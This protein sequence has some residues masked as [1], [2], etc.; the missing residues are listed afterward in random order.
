[1]V[2][3]IYLLILISVFWFASR[4][5]AVAII[6]RIGNVIPHSWMTKEEIVSILK[7]RKISDQYWI[8][9]IPMSIKDILGLWD[10]HKSK[11]SRFFFFVRCDINCILMQLEQAGI[12]QKKVVDTI[13][14][15]EVIKESIRLLNE[16]KDLLGG[17]PQKGFLDDP[18]FSGE[19]T[20][21]LKQMNDCKECEE[22]SV[23]IYHWRKIPSG[24]RSRKKIFVTRVIA[25]DVLSI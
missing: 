25:P 2:F 13:H 22:L 11:E 16:L 24:K 9:V 15:L 17:E 12:I 3:L 5:N 4:C 23:N 10:I 6:N 7:T 18:L 14:F 20:K 19:N 1:M 21:I 8:L